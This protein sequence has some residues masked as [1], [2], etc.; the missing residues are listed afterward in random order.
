MRTIILHLL[1]LACAAT[2]FGQSTFGTI[3]G[4]V[5][6]PSSA[7]VSGAKVAITNEGTGALRSTATD[8]AGSYRLTNLDAGF[9]TINVAAQNFTTISRKNVQLPARELVHLDFQ[10][11]LASAQ[12]TT[13]EVTADAGVISQALTVS[14]SKSGDLISSLAINFRATNAP[15]PLVLLP[16]SPGVQTDQAG[17]YSLSGG[18]PNSTS[19]SI[20]GISTQQ[21]RSGGPSRDLFPSV[22]TIAEFRVNTAGNSA[23][24]SQPTDL[25]VISKSGTNQFH[26]SGFWYF[27]RDSL[28]ARD[29]F[30]A[31]KPKV[32]ADDYGVNIGG[33][34]IRNKTFFIFT[35]E[36]VRRPQDF[37]LN[38]IVPPTPW[39]S[40]DLSSVTKPILNPFSGVPF[41]GNKIPAQLLNSSTQKM[42]SLF[43]SPNNP[44]NTS[45]ADPNYTAN[46]GGD[47]SLNGYDGRLD[48]IFNDRHK[49]F[50]RY[51]QK[52]ITDS[53]TGGSGNYNVQLGLNTGTTAATNLGGAW[54]W[55]MRSNLINEFRAGYTFYQIGANNYPLAKQG[56]ALVK[57]FGIQGLPPAPVN[58]LGGVPEIEISS[59][60]GGSSSPGHPRLVDNR[61]FT[62]ADAATWIRGR[63]TM[64]FGADFRRYSY[65]DQITF[66]T[67]DEYGDY[68]FFGAVTGHDF[69]DYL[70]GLPTA[71]AFA[72]NGPDGEPFGYHYGGFFQDD[73]K[74]SRRLTVNLGLRYE[75][76]PAFDD[77]THQLGQ[78]DRDFPGGRLIT[79]GTEGLNLVAPSWRNQV[80]NTPF[81]TNDQA[82]LPI[83][84]RRTWKGNIQPRA[85][86]AW[87]VTGDNKTLIRGSVGVYSVPVLGAV[88]YSLLGVNTS[89]F[90]QFNTSA[91]KPLIFPNPFGGTSADLGFPSYRRANDPN[92]QDPRVV[93]WNVSIDREIGHSLIAGVNYTGSYTY[94]LLYSPDLNQ[95]KPNT[96]GYNALTATPALR[97]QNLLYPNFNEVLTRDNGPTSNY[98]ATS[99]LLTRRFA[100]DLTFTNSYTLA[101]QT[102]NA[103]GSAPNA[104]TPN[105]GTTGGDNGGNVLNK[106]DIES[107]RG[108]AAYTRRH[109]FVSTF[110][111][112]LPFGRGKKFAGSASR[113]AN[114]AV[115]GWRAT[116]VVTLQTGTFLTPTF[117][118]TDP[119]G[120]NP[121]Q[122]S[123]NSYQR[124]DCS[125]TD[126]NAT[127]PTR[128][129][130]FNPA[131]FS[132]PA[133]SIGR[134]GNC[135]VGILRGP[136]TKVFSMALGKSLAITERFA[137]R[138]EA[139]FSNLFNITNL[140][141][142]NTRFSNSPGTV[143]GAFGRITATQSAEQAGP[144]TIQMMLRFT[145]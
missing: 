125:G 63:H 6:D 120:T 85:G 130:Y 94:N 75:I 1:L 103:L 30:A 51:S 42:L 93:Q 23:E 43:V 123:E 60:L 19:F 100:R 56:D 12:A 67:G 52:D 144:R 114:L 140:G 9:Y 78:F 46:F 127:N 17:T 118:G 137:I 64:K 32:Q 96:T 112:E 77:K 119:S 20:D 49:V 91:A 40:G 34:L 65:K 73:I 134:F 139:Q 142:P 124:P 107:D 58:G 3:E 59:F 126:G 89:N 133:N 16:L 69:A 72:Q 25:T 110:S 128:S 57:S 88:L 27:Q 8:L 84:L 13:I 105:G 33:P 37:L 55:I 28:N 14:D 136:G 36:G 122:R 98:S 79:Q 24:Y 83:T 66:L 74:L 26:G 101:F 145:F 71:T 45:I 115:G 47:Y 54:T 87:N 35:Y 109:R 138:Y 141:G 4:V 22:E 18:L 106:F 41:P 44:A 11:P 81:V 116:G 86:A 53:G 38:Q 99:L 15:S 90:V 62:F 82:G 111:Y 131:A 117:T 48:H 108:N 113:A 2:A 92:L 39:R 29:T 5:T 121:A 61:I 102:T 31:S 104:N 10:L 135:G 70:L 97:K 95:L 80:G 129:Q 143:N 7:V 50:F 132:V 68:F 76:N 21:V